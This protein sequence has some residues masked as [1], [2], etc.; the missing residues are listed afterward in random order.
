MFNSPFNSRNLLVS[1]SKEYRCPKCFLI[2][3]INIS[4]NENKLFMST[5]CTNNHNY[6]KPFDEMEMMCKASPILNYTCELCKNF[7]EAKNFSNIYFYCSNCFK[8]FCLKHGE[9]HSLKEGHKIFINKK[10]DS[11]CTEHEGTTVVGYCKKHNKNYCFLCQ[12]FNENNNK[13]DEKL[14][15]EQIKKYE[16]ENKN[17]EKIIKEMEVL[18]NNY[19]KFF[20][21]LEDDF[22]LFKDYVNKKILFINEI[23][24]FYKEKTKDCDINY[25]MKANIENNCFDLT[26]TNQ[27]LMKKINSQIKIINELKNFFKIKEINNVMNFIKEEEKETKKEVEKT[28]DSKKDIEKLKTKKEVEKTKD[29]KKEIEKLKTKKEVEKTKDFKKEIEKLKDFEIEKTKIVNTLNNNENYINCLKILD[30]GR[31]AAGDSSSN[32]VIYNKEN[33]KPEIIIKNNLGNLFNI[34]QIK[35]KFLA[36]SFAKDSTIKIIKIKKNNVYDEIQIIKNAHDDFIIKI[37]ELK[38][39]NLISFSYDCSFKIWKLNDKNKYEKIFRF[40]D[41]DKLNDGLEIKE[42]EILYVKES[43]S[44]SIVFYDL[45]TNE[46][47][48]TLNRLDLFIDFRGQRIIKLTEKN[49]AVAGDGK[50]YLIDTNNYVIL[51]KIES[52]QNCCI[53]KLTN[54]LFLVGDKYGNVFQ[55]KLK[56]KKLIDESKKYKLHGSRIYSMAFLNGF[57]ISGGYNEIKIWKI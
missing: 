32:L 35:N 9:T 22:F 13:F 7:K 15:E 45:E 30:D 34:T 39:K 2:P 26:E 56:D 12:H 29:S 31:L 55:Y 44:N 6:S 18:F 52:N 27:I 46:K 47:I 20:N 42:N 14:N 51:D 24:N 36:C 11:I 40:K 50:V 33:F 43:I 49:I 28:K 57:F 53:L 37:I 1:N 23:I 25:Q 21:E 38:N 8:F 16:N 10:L 17:N 48:K 19:K 5:K 41:S 4:I 54:N 3:F